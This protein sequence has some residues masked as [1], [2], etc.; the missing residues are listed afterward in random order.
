MARSSIED[1]GGK[2]D[3]GSLTIEEKRDG[4]MLLASPDITV[5]SSTS[6]STDLGTLVPFSGTLS[7]GH[8]Y[9]YVRPFSEYVGLVAGYIENL[10]AHFLRIAVTLIYIMTHSCV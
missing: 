5:K 8:M 9:T 6:D 10:D 2:E 7:Q 3:Q 4:N 1:D